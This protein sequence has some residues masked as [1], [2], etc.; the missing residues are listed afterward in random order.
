MRWEGDEQGRTG[1]GGDSGRRA[2][3]QQGPRFVT[4]DQKTHVFVQNVQWAWHAFSSCSVGVKTCKVARHICFHRFG[5]TS[6]GNFTADAYLDRI[7]DELWIVWYVENESQV[8]FLGS[9]LTF[10]QPV[11]WTP[12]QVSGQPA[13]APDPVLSGTIDES[14]PSGFSEPRMIASGSEGSIPPQEASLD[15][16]WKMLDRVGA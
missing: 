9:C 10:E 11:D 5:T 6:R 16:V 13:L 14:H 8:C 1:E 4:L 15:A 2:V 7:I 3:R 12:F